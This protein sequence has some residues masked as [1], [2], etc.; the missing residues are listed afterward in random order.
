MDTKI[1]RKDKVK[2]LRKKLTQ[3][4]QEERQALI[5]H[6]GIVTVEGHRLSDTNNVLVQFQFPN[7]TVVGGYNQWQKANRQV[8]KGEHGFV[9]WFPTGVKKDQET[10]PDPDDIHFLTAVVFDISQTEEKGEES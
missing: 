9:I 7:A 5:D 4:S 6:I 1:S 8:K 10:T 3:L 2:E